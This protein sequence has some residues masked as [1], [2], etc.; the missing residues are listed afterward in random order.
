MDSNL[1]LGLALA[2]G[3]VLAAA[4]GLRAFLPLLA[5][6][7]A[8]RLGW[9]HLAPAMQWLQH[10]AALS[11]LGAATLIEIVGDKIP[12][13]DHALDAIATAVRPA[14]AWIAGVAVLAHWPAPWPELVAIALGGGAFAVH[15]L[16][17]KTRL[18]SSVA[19]LGHANP[20]LSIFEDATTLVLLALAILAPLIA[21]VL[22]VLLVM[23]IVRWA[24]RRRVRPASA[25]R[26][27]AS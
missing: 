3:V 5:L 4:C 13:V 12:V 26:I 21:L 2:S 27:L 19:T 22:T 17:A 16:K 25:P 7:I 24:R 10:P 1:Q 8:G 18:G 23:A 9:L 20:L 15:A 14:A 6:G 11:C